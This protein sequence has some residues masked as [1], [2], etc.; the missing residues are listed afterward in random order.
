MRGIGSFDKR[1]GEAP[2]L[3]PLLVELDPTDKPQILGAEV[4]NVSA[5]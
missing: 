2:E 1:G 5:S 4:W 3:M